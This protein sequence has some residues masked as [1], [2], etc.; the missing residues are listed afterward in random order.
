MN[1]I[2][3]ASSYIQDKLI[4]F[5]KNNIFFFLLNLFFQL[6]YSILYMKLILVL[7]SIIH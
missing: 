1:V 6:W 3:Y 4:F 7:V 2:N 5:L